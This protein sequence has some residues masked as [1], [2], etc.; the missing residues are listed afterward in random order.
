MKTRAIDAQR[1]IDDARTQVGISDAQQQRASEDPR[2]SAEVRARLKVSTVNALSNIR[3]I[4]ERLGGRE[5]IVRRQVFN[6][7]DSP[8]PIWIR[9]RKLYALIDELN[10]F[11]G[12]NVACR[13]GCAHCCHTQVA[14]GLAEAEMLGRAIGRKPKK[15]V[16]RNRQPGHY[17]SQPYGYH[18]PCT[19]L[20]NNECSIYEHRPL[21]CRKLVN[22]DIDDLL[23]QLIPPLAVPVPY[24]DRTEFDFANVAI[25][26]SGSSVPKSADIREYF[27]KTETP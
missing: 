20:V 24:L 1:I 13:R 27:P 21:A 22:A 18:T 10:S 15:N 5:G 19:F 23:C 26:T 2:L 14:M 7:L 9:L 16:S 17:D 25:C 8:D 4:R 11:N 3:V 6:L 12:Q